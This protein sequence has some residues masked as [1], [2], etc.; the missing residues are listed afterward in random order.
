MHYMENYTLVVDTVGLNIISAQ[1][2]E[3]VLL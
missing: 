2:W 1:Y 3:M